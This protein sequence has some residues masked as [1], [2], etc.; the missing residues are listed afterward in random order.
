MSTQTTIVI[1]GEPH[2]Q[3]EPFSNADLNYLARRVG[4]NK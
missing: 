3:S 2:L 1:N 4:R